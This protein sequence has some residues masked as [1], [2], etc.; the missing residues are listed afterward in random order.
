MTVV[1]E[2]DTLTTTG[3]DVSN[4]QQQVTTI[5]P[6]SVSA[7]ADTVPESSEEPSSEPETAATPETETFENPTLSTT[8]PKNDTPN[9]EPETTESTSFQ[10]AAV[11][12]STSGYVTSTSELAASEA[13]TSQT[14]PES[15]PTSATSDPE[16]LVTN[17]QASENSGNN[18]QDAKESSEPEKIIDPLP[19]T[20]EPETA[21]SEPEPVS[22]EP[23]NITSEPE[24][25][26]SEPET[27]TSEPEPEYV[28]SEPEPVTSE[29]KTATAEIEYVTVEPESVTSEPETASSEPKSETSES[30]PVSSEPEAATSE[31]ESVTSEPENLT[32]EPE[33]EP[34]TSEPEPVTIEPESEP[35]SVTSEPEIVT[36]EPKPVTSQPVTPDPEPDENSENNDEG[37]TPETVTG[38]LP[39]IVPGID[40][41]NSAKT[42]SEPE[43]SGVTDESPKIE[44]EPE[45]GTDGEGGEVTP[46]LEPET[47]PEVA[48][49]PQPEVGISEPGNESFTSSEPMSGSEPF[50]E[51]ESWPEPGPDWSSAYAVWGPAWPSHV[52]VFGLLFLFLSTTTIV[53]LIIIFYESKGVFRGKLTLSLLCMTLFFT[54][55]RALSLLSDPY[56]TTGNIPWIASRLIWSFAHPAI[57]SAFSLILLVLLD[58]TRMSIGPPRFQ[59]LPAILSVTGFH[60]LLV[61]SSDIVVF[62]Q[63]VAKVM[64][65]LCQTLF[66][67]YGLLLTVGYL[68]VGVKIRRNCVAGQDGDDSDTIQQLVSLSFVSSAASALIGVTQI[69]S[70]VS[71]FGIYSNAVYVDSW[72]WWSLQ[73]LMRVEEIIPVFI[74]LKLASRSV[75]GSYLSK[76]RKCIPCE[77]FKKRLGSKARITPINVK[78][79]SEMTSVDVGY[80]RGTK[81]IE[82]NTSNT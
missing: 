65:L 61:G 21:S 31:S 35:E 82:Y 37:G 28:T 66:I 3:S 9:T 32:S 63:P 17:S 40:I 51:P 55:L 67:L 72:S 7:E 80:T 14:E 58:T 2:A 74:I 71:V 8:T 52:F 78:P 29:P 24:H 23:D 19:V 4:A 76:I 27:V 33:S 75:R 73:S 69:Y 79:V 70:A 5:G 46:S 49:V 25:V 47:H 59:K 12:M 6:A 38:S 81:N 57:T 77:V 44:P 1:A 13:V 16:Q 62:Y 56:S 15:E 41:E 34:V 36:S 60:F 48:V 26:S 53:F 64:L 11:I 68:Y 39:H 22:S 54:F 30:E 20:S 45:T 42:T 10:N 43:S 50:A 18:E